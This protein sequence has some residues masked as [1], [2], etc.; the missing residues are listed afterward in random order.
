VTLAQE[1]ASSPIVAIGESAQIGP[2]EITVTDLVAGDE[3]AAM[4]AD[5][6]AENPAAPDGYAYVLVNLSVTNLG[7][8]P[9][10]IQMTDFAA[11]GSDGVLRRTQ[12]VVPPDPMLQFVVEAGQTVEGWIAP[13]VDDLSNAVLWFD[14]PFLGGN[15]ANGLFALA[16][17]ATLTIP[18]DLDPT[19]TDAGS[20]PAAPAAVGET[21]KIGGWE[22]TITQVIGGQEVYDM[23]DFR[24]QALG[25]P[26]SDPGGWVDRAVGL[27][28]TVR[29]H[30][31]FP[32]WFSPITFEAA[33]ANGEVWDHTLTMT[34]PEP[35]VSREYL[36]GGSGEGWATLSPADYADIER[37]KVSP[38]KLDGGARYIVLDP[39]PLPAQ[40]NT[41]AEPEAETGTEEE[42]TPL[43]VAVGDLVVTSEDLVNL[44]SD[45]STTGEILQ[46]LPLGTQ[47]EITGDAV[48]ADGYTW[49]PVTVVE[50]AESG[51]VVADFLAPAAN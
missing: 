38:F 31:P 50:S 25:P 41:S 3:A 11:T 35:D 40:A 47:L 44:R 49:Y 43:Q 6:N 22:I 10:S 30:N 27:R 46:E 20:E 1:F 42:A 4:L 21:V 7:E 34:G 18:T 33:D 17:G 32:A 45:P 5:I 28:A 13:I 51:Y 39:S 9:R 2:W 15:W 12:V 16:D 36:P 29:N 8:A 14:S 48:E 19:D 23:S 26:S 24:L 37:V